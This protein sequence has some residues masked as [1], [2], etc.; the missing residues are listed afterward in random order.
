MLCQLDVR[1]YALID[2]MC[3]SFANGFNVLTG[4]TGAGKSLII[5]CVGLAIGGRA[6]ADMVRSG[7]DSAVVDALFD[8]SDVPEAAAV[9]S[10]MG[11]EPEPDGTLVLSRQIW[12]QGR[13]QCRVNGRT[14]TASA[15]SQLGS[16]LVDIY[17]QH[18]YQSLTRPA[19][20]IA[21][22]DSLGGPSHLALLS[23][24]RSLWSRWLAV[25]ADLAQL[26]AKEREMNQR[27]DIL[28]YQVNEI[29]AAAPVA[30]EDE[31]LAQERQVIS[32]AE[33]LHDAALRAYEGLYG[34]DGEGS[35][36]AYD[37]LAAAASELEPAA[38]IDPS[39][40]EHFEAISEACLQVGIVAKA[41]RSYSDSTDYDPGRLSEIEER[42]S[43]IARL[44]RKYGDT[45][46]EILDYLKRASEE[47]ES[48]AGADERTRSLE[49]D[50]EKLGTDL[51]R[52][53]RELSTLRETEAEWLGAAVCDQLKEL[54]MPRAKFVVAL[55]PVD[56]EHIV[57]G[58]G[59]GVA[60]GPSGSDD[61][62]FM[63]S[64][65][66]GEE[67]RPLARIASGGELSRV[68]L[69]I[70]S[71][72][73]AADSMPTMV[74]DEVDQGIG[75]EA[76]VAVATRLKLIGSVRQVLAV[77]HL[78]QIAAVSGRHLVV[79]KEERQGRTGV[80]SKALSAEERVRELARMLAGDRPSPV[81]VEHAQEM[82]RQGQETKW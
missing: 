64:A 14:V 79:E 53:A 66:I 75:G 69:A 55:R 6:S 27:A 50:E 56:S 57:T 82:L 81:T 62:E 19:R 22:L 17:G 71:V 61:V 49:A 77:T 33:R 72:L 10:D 51:A 11:I 70:K 35:R 2:S 26:R 65:N 73:A 59:A 36:P 20:H 9:L 8:T 42:L 12:R 25:K 58:D 47:L 7:A 78:P 32:N 68:M 38:R 24:Y 18:D 4:E 54:N 28:S 45:T 23:R 76:A 63:F 15:L 31:A 39:L 29:T 1:N 30:G 21:L 41:L 37:A 13:S 16:V 34:G 5:D 74:F 48:L 80:I 46:A 40:T 43:L 52:A 67:P 60:V 3:M 44:K